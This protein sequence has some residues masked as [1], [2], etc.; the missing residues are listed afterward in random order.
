M[1]N[2]GA[3]FSNSVEIK[4]TDLAKAMLLAGVKG[5]SGITSIGAGNPPSD[6]FTRSK[7]STVTVISNAEAKRLAKV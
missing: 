3:K 4:V 1:T 2:V 5:S 7:D 6:T